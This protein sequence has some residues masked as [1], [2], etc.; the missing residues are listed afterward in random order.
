MSGSD[1]ERAL[2]DVAASPENY[3]D[4]LRQ[5]GRGTEATTIEAR[6]ETIRAKHTEQNPQNQSGLSTSEAGFVPYLAEVA[7][8]IDEIRDRAPV[9]N[10]TLPLDTFAFEFLRRS[11]D[12]GDVEPKLGR[13]PIERFFCGW[14]W[15]VDL[16]HQVRPSEFAAREM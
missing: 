9:V 1:P 12:I 5:T 4:L 13:I 14:R 10:R 8:G 11:F 15:A 3:A 7:V 6:T 16:N 2:V